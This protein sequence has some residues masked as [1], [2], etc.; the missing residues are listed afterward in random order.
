MG[1]GNVTGYLFREGRDWDSLPLMG[2]GNLEDLELIEQDGVFSLPLMGIG[3]VRGPRPEHRQSGLITP[4]GDWKRERIPN[5]AEPAKF[6][7]TPHGDWKQLMKIRSL[8]SCTISLPL[9]GIGNRACSPAR[10]D[11]PATHYPSWGLETNVRVR[12]GAH[13]RALITPHG[14]WKRYIAAERDHMEI[15][16]LPLMGIGNVLEQLWGAFRLMDSL[17]LMGIGNQRLRVRLGLQQ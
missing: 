4:H 13:N 2:I 5:R 9:M 14:D 10:N 3:N 8:A 17:P 7:I 11:R 16:S 12:L 1:I 6:L 15:D